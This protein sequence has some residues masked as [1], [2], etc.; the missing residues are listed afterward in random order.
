MLNYYTAAALAKLD[1][2]SE[3]PI[4]NHHLNADYYEVR[5]ESPLKIRF[6]G[7]WEWDMLYEIYEW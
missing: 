3:V 6:K 1:T 5:Q 7:S 4:S 2:W